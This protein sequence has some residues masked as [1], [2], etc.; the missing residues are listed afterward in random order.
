MTMHLTQV[1]DRSRSVFVSALFCLLA[2]NDISQA[3]SPEQT[4]TCRQTDVFTAG[5]DGY[6]TYRIPAITVTKK[7]TLLA[8]CE[9]RKKGSGDSGDIDLVLKRSA[10]GGVTWSRQQIVWDDQQNTCGNPCPIV[11]QQTG[12]IWLLLT[13]NRG[14]DHEPQII[15]RT[16]KDTRRVY[17]TSSE[18]DGLTWAAPKEI[19]SDTKKPDWTW[20]A[21]G[22]CNGIQLTRGP[23]KDRLVAPCDHITAEGKRFYSHVIY[24]DDHGRTWK[25]GGVSPR[26]KLNESTVVE[27][28]DGALMLNMRNYDGKKTR[29]VCLSRDGG[30]TWNGFYNDAALVEPVCQ[31]SIL[32]WRWPEGGAKG[33]IAFSNPASQRREKMTVRLSD[34]EGRTWRVANLLHADPAA[35]SCLVAL[36]DGSLGCLYEA[37][38][39]H[40]YEK[41]VFARMTQKWFE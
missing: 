27:L 32:R 5:T 38:Q 24:S 31:A 16:S 39:K 15:A 3:A 40:P 34:D 36:P 11:D 35:Y 9:G 28:A 23:H 41:I 25:L 17:V 19:T 12:T 20:Y 1:P 7:G 21:T 33:L 10:D 13:W 14:D 4:G 22:P 26:D 18:D 30:S 8:F 37:G 29:G 6:H 2:V